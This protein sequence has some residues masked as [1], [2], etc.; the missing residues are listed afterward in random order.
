MNLITQ[1]VRVATLQNK[2]KLHII[3]NM[4]FLLAE[5]LIIRIHLIGINMA[6]LLQPQAE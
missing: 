4:K 3:P 6:V 5:T 1:H 2:N